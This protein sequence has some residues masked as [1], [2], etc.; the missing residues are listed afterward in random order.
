VPACRA[1]I[2]ST[3][4]N[5]VIVCGFLGCDALPFNPILAT[6]PRM[7]H[8]RRPRA[9]GSDRLGALVEFA[10]GESR[11]PQAGSRSVQLESGS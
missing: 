9:S 2:H 11:D 3:K 7:L 8:V 1:V 5:C 10:V 4:S 6:L